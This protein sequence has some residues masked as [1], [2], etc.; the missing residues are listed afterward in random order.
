MAWRLAA[1]AVLLF[2][3]AFV[4]FAVAGGL[5]VLRWRWVALLHLPVLAWAAFVEFT[6]RI[7]PLTPLENALREAGGQAGYQGGFV[8]HYLLPMLYPADLT[9]E[10]QFLLGGGLLAFNLAVYAAVAWQARRRRFR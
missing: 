4:A 8:E 10:L 1:D 3:L 6:G 5:L 7:C 9:R 2:H